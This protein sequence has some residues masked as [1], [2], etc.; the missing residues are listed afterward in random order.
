MLGTHAGEFG[1]RV[2]PCLASVGVGIGLNDISGVT[3]KW[4][5]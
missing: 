5:I 2:A 4:W 3:A 1:F